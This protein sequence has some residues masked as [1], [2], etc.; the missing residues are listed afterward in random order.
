MQ[1][2]TKCAVNRDRKKKK[3]KKIISELRLMIKHAETN[4]LVN[5][6]IL[7]TYPKTIS[8]PLK[9]FTYYGYTE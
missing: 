3:I 8:K 9:Q 1:W 2:V 5:C 4:K 6:S 7:T